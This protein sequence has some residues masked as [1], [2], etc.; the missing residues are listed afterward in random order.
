MAAY[1]TQ[2]LSRNPAAPLLGV[3]MKHLIRALWRS[4]SPVF[5]PATP[6]AVSP[7]PFPNSWR[8][9]APNAWCR[10]AGHVVVHCA[11]E[12]DLGWVISCRSHGGRLLGA[13]VHRPVL[14]DAVQIAPLVWER[15]HQRTLVPVD[16]RF[17]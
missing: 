12:D 6:E 7:S 9:V 10:P 14:S 2:G 16:T 8:R 1:E 5:R 13:E 17:V 15:H 4:L 11:A 3:H